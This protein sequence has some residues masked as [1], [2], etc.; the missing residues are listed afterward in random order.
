MKNKDSFSLYPLGVE[1]GLRWLLF[2]FS[3]AWIECVLCRVLKITSI[4]LFI[5]NNIFRISGRPLIN[6]E[7]SFITFQ[8]LEE[9]LY[10]KIKKKYF[11]FK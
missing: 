5:N 9:H 4:E 2:V 7:T 3:A 6:D 1:I 11:I 8:R 10:L